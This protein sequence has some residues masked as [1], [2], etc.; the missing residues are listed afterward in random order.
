MGIKEFLTNL[1]GIA[2]AN[3]G[4]NIVAQYGATTSAA[5][6][7][8]RDKGTCLNTSTYV[9]PIPNISPNQRASLS[10]YETTRQS[11]QVAYRNDPGKANKKRIIDASEAAGLAAAD[12]YFIPKG[13]KSLACECGSGK[14]GEF[15]KVYA[16]YEGTSITEVIVVECKGG[17]SPLGCRKNN[18]QGTKEYLLDIITNMEN[19]TKTLSSNNEIKQTTTI[20]RKFSKSAITYYEVRQ[21]FDNNDK[22]QDTHIT[23]FELKW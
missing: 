13:Y 12:A 23:Q 17:T 4:D 9:Q 2:E 16:K 6:A 21:P 5:F 11:A 14:Q 8:Y 10:G 19:K 18:Q 1:S 3:E 20:L 7:F 15:D 22:L